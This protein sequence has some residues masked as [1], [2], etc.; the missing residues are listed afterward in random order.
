MTDDATPVDIL[1]SV[2]THA[3][4]DDVRRAVKPARRVFLVKDSADLVPQ[5]VTKRHARQMLADLQAG[6][7]TVV[8]TARVEG[9]DLL[10]RT[11]EWLGNPDV[12]ATPQDPLGAAAAEARSRHAASPPAAPA[13]PG[14]PVSRKEHS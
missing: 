14:I 10:I 7:D 11:L 1:K 5:R 9:S 2:L 13:G 6:S 4:I 3:G 8:V 12:L